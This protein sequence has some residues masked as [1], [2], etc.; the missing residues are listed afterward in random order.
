MV[1]NTQSYWV[2]TFCSS[3]GI[4]ETRKHRVPERDPVSETLCFLVLRIPDDGQNP[5]TEEL[6]Y[7]SILTRTEI[8]LQILLKLAIFKFHKYPFSN[9]R[10]QT[11]DAV[12]RMCAFLPP[13]LAKAQKCGLALFVL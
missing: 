13:F 11:S 7:C 3:S 10:L 2:Y 12:K 9:C 5:R 1:Y 8:F 6:R 4:L